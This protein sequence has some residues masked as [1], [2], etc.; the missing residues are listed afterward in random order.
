MKKTE[1]SLFES[2][3]NKLNVL[4]MTNNVVKRLRRDIIQRRELKQQELELQKRLLPE[5]EKIF[6]VQSG[7]SDQYRLKVLS[8]Y[9]EKHLLLEPV[10]EK[11]QTLTSYGYG[12]ES[13]NSI[14]KDCSAAIILLSENAETNTINPQVFFEVGYFMGR[15]QHLKR[16]RVLILYE[17][18]TYMPEEFSS[19]SS[20]FYDKSIKKTFFQLQSQLKSWG[21][22]I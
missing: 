6:I 8:K 14:R 5:N 12:F 15:F 7:K 9:L 18:N 11:K 22:Q 1:I 20:V 13:F 10:F 17:R 2:A 21:F 16:K 3:R 4:E 19:I